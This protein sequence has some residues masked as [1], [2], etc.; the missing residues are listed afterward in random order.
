LEAHFKLKILL[1][2]AEASKRSELLNDFIKSR[3]T[4]DYKLNFGVD[5]MTKDVEFR[6]DEKA[7]LTIWDIGGQQRFEFVRSTFYKGASGVLVVFDL[8]RKETYE[9]IKTWLTEIRK[10]TEKDIPFVLIGNKSDLIEEASQTLDR[11]KIS[12]LAE[13]EGMT[14]IET[15]DKKELEDVFAELIRKIIDKKN[16]KK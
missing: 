8:T 12:A 11:E 9:E 1:T 6:P 13:D 10:V 16:K 3:F 15:G 7:T 14:Y 2:G 4:S 5:I